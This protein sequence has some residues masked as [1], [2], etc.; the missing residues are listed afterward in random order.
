MASLKE[1][2]NKLSY[3][4]LD[5]LK[6]MALEEASLL[7]PKLQIYYGS[8]AVTILFHIIL[9][10]MAVDG[11]LATNEYEVARK[12]IEPIIGH[13]IS[14][15]ELVNAINNC[16]SGYSE[17]LKKIVYI[18][19]KLRSVDDDA[20]VHLCALCADICAA[21]GTIHSDE[22]YWLNMFLS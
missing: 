6:S 17:N 11:S 14:I 8:D 4:P 9:C 13:P 12:I 22:E 10:A 18:A 5:S 20:F 19:H 21:N 1:L 3:A 7:L 16:K 2:L 15:D